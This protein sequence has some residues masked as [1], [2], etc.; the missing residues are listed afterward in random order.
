MIGK[1]YERK[2]SYNIDEIRRLLV[3]CK[4]KNHEVTLPMIAKK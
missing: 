1:K 2:T 3:L 4:R